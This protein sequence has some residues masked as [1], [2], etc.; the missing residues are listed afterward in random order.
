MPLKET[1]LDIFLSCKLLLL[2][3]KG[4][5]DRKA[6]RLLTLS[7][8]MLYL[9]LSSMCM[10]VCI[11]VRVDGDRRLKQKKAARWIFASLAIG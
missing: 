6:A 5:E 3:R 7:E 10:Y 4:H 9:S 1:A 11:D 2:A 8:A